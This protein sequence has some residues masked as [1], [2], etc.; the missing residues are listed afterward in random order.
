MEDSQ[1]DFDMHIKRR[2][3]NK[4]RTSDMTDWDS[5]MS[6][7][8]FLQSVILSD[9]KI[10]YDLSTLSLFPGYLHTKK[11]ILLANINFNMAILIW[12][13]DAFGD[14]KIF[15]YKKRSSSISLASFLISLLL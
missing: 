5:F 7:W 9:I 12:H 10:T 15:L 2:A 1:I 13:L 6:D 14:T 3:E 4:R 11:N 8:D